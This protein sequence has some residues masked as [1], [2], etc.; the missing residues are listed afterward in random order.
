LAG[1]EIGKQITGDELLQIAARNL[2]ITSG[3]GSIDPVTGGQVEGFASIASSGA[4]RITVTENLPGQGLILDGAGGTGMFDALGTALVRVSGSG[5]PITVSGHIEVKS[6]AALAPREDALVIAGA[7][8]VDES[9]LAAFLRA[10]E[11]TRAETFEQD[12]NLQARSS[13]KGQPNVCK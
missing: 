10:T 8:L 11:A 2:F 9:L 4:I 7:P 5:F 3:T 12:A 6:P 1:T 13:A